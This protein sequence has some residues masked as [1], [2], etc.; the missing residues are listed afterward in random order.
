MR[1]TL[2]GCGS[3]S[4]NSCRASLVVTGPVAGSPPMV[5]PSTS[6]VT[7]TATP[8]SSKRTA[9]PG[10]RGCNGTRASAALPRR[11]TPD[12]SQVSVVIDHQPYGP[13]SLPAYCSR[14]LDSSCSY[15]L[16][17]FRSSVIEHPQLPHQED[18]LVDDVAQA[19]VERFALAVPG[20]AVDPYDDRL[21]GRV[22]RRRRLKGG[23]HLAGV[24]RMDAR[25]V[26]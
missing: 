16:V 2:T 21:V 9:S 26:L 6:G 19:E 4:M 17:A 22:G 8:S 7:V 13:A 25:V 11:F 1:L 23:G 20:L 15:A 10:R 3:A 12:S 14:Q 24:Q 18:P 5:T